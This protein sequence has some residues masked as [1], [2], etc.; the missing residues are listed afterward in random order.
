ML[1]EILEQGQ[2]GEEKYMNF[3]ACLD[4]EKENCPNKVGSNNETILV[5]FDLRQDVIIKQNRGIPLLQ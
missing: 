2:M 3:R 1:S 4:S 5:L